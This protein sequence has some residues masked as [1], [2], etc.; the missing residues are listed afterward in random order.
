MTAATMNAKNAKNEAKSMARRTMMRAM[1]GLFGALAIGSLA[2]GCSMVAGERRT[3]IGNG[4]SFFGSG[5]SATR[6]Y[7]LAH[8]TAIEVGSAFKVDVTQAADYAVS[9]TAD[10]NV[11]DQADVSVDG[12]TLR[13]MMKPGSFMNAGY[14]ASVK[15]PTLKRLQVSGASTVGL[16]GIKTDETLDLRVSGAS[17][18]NGDVKANSLNLDLSGASKST[19]KGTAASANLEMNGAS[20]AKLEDLLTKHIRANLSGASQSTVN[21]SENLDA[22]LSGASKLTYAGQ[23]TVSSQSVTGASTLARK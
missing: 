22:N 9:V 21:A 8:F 19:L 23:P 15:L 5:K 6:E 18:V 20:G 7:K 2:T 3:N 11:L 14:R 10:D 4:P 13:I 17:T 1:A 16:A 12:E